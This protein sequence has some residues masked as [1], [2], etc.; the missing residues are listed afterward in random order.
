MK[1]TPSN[2]SMSCYALRCL[3]LGQARITP[4]S[5]TKPTLTSIGEAQNTK[6]TLFCFVAYLGRKDPTR[7]VSEKHEGVMAQRRFVVISADTWPTGRTASALREQQPDPFE[8]TSSYSTASLES[9]WFRFAKECAQST[10]ALEVKPR[11]F[12]TS[13]VVE[14]TTTERTSRNKTENKLEEE[15]MANRRG[16]LSVP[17]CLKD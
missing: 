3:V 17:E 4:P 7:Y 5:N 11:V 9:L 8:H 14:L 13:V 1:K 15:Y 2:C 16:F 6:Y 12:R 10:M